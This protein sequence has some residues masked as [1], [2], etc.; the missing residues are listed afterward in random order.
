MEIKKELQ[1]AIV[2][3]QKGIFNEARKVYEEILNFNPDVFEA[4]HNLGMLLKSLNKLDEAERSFTKSI[5]LKPDF[6]IS[7]YQMGNTKYKLQKFKESETCYEKAIS[8]NSNFLEAY[9]NLGRSQRELRKLKEAEE[10]LR[11]A[12]KINPDFPETNTLLG[13]I[14]FDRGR[15][16]DDLKH[17]DLDKLIEGKKILLK[18]IKLNPDYAISHLNLGLILQEL[19]DLNDAK[20]SFEKSLKLDPNSIYAKYNLDILLNQIDLLDLMEIKEEKKDND[21]KIFLKNFDKI[22]FVTQRKPNTELVDLLYKLNSTELNKTVGGPL[23]GNGKTSDYSLLENNNSVLKDLKKDLINIIKKEINSNVF[24]IDSFFNILGAGG[25][26]V[27]HHHLNSFDKT[28]N[29]DKQKYSLTYYLDVGDQNCKEPGIFKLY[30]PNEEVL[31]TN[32]M[33]MII[34]SGRKHSA[35][36]EGK[37]DRVMIG[38]NFYSII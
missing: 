2:L 4:H 13:L 21:N 36:Y 20:E 32:G 23:Y 9:I 19:G 26:S 1:K 22:P 16:S 33:I 28:F 7:H 24:I 34:P 14:L 37:K 6:A 8:L 29:L 38:L 15:L 3:Q 12:K 10:N 31:P 17:K 5:V 27:P 25:G 30:E 11:K 35:V 18:S